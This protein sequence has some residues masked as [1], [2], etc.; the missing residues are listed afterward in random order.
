M[1][2]YSV[3]INKAALDAITENPNLKLVE[4][5]SFNRKIAGRFLYVNAEKLTENPNFFS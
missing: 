1:E 3:K 5:H 4:E 2:L